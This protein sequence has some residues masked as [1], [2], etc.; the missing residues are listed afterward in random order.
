MA[1]LPFDDISPGSANA[2][3]ALG[4][5]EVILNRLSSVAGLSVIARSSSFALPAKLIEARN[6][7]ERLDA[8]FLVEGSVQHE[9]DRLRVAVHLVETNAG[10]FGFVSKFRSEI[11]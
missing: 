2:Y 11:E 9:D 8:G 4:L 6:I 7:G 3:L 5:P 10:T 1:V